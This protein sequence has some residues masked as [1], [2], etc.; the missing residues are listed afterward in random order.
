MVS[1]KNVQIEYNI[2]INSAGFSVGHSGPSV[3]IR[4]NLFKG[5]R[6]FV[7]RNWASYAGQTI[8][9]YNSFIDMSGIVLELPSGYSPAAMI[10]TENYWGTN[11]TDTIDS[12][13]YD[14]KDDITCAGFIEYLPI[15][16]EPHSDTPTLPLMVKFTYSP[17]KVYAYGTVT[18]DAS[19][20]FGLYSSIVNYTWDFGDGNITTTLSPKIKHGYAMPGNYNVTLTVADE[21]GFRNSTTTSI[22]V[23]EDNVSPATMD[24]YDG[25]WRNKDFTITL[26]AIDHE[27][28]VAETYYRINNGSVKAVSING[29]PLIIVEGAN[30]TLEY[31]SVDN[32]GNE[33]LPHKMLTCVKLDKTEPSSS[34]S[35][36]GIMGEND[37]FVSNVTATLTANDMLSGIDSILYSF[38]NVKWENYV[39]PFNISN[40]GQ[41]TIYFKAVDKAGNMETVKME[42]VKIDKTP[43]IANAGRDRTVT[44]GETI[45][46]DASASTDNIGIASYEWNFGDGTTKMGKN[47]THQYSNPGTYTVTLTVKD[48]AGNTATHSITLTATSSHSPTPTPTPTPTYGAIPA[49]LI[50]ATIAIALLIVI[51]AVSVYKRKTRKSN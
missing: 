1:W 31:W 26:T 21:F 28:G 20:S 5:N 34:M 48:A 29:Q 46:F 27:S 36:E 30:N 22:K 23:L 41:V 15:L 19:A 25:E 17:T 51:F 37:W 10:A 38:D 6:G 32:A 44:V 9:K 13:I 42:T 12:M 47:V 35:L 40:E 43:P 14:K 11:D 7:V 8:V 3:Y 4:Y 49:W 2:F 16:T 39:G 24:D 33:E 50:G 18:F 45:N